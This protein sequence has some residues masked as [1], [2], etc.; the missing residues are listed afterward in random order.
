V[1]KG[2]H[3]NTAPFKIIGA[4]LGIAGVCIIIWWAF[5]YLNFRKL[6]NNL[7]NYEQLE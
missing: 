4:T 7:D 1:W 5:S 2:V 6:K 3:I